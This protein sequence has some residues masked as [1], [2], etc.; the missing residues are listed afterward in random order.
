MFGV[1]GTGASMETVGKKDKSAQGGR[2]QVFERPYKGP[3]LT[4]NKKPLKDFEQKCDMTGCAS[5]EF[6][7]SLVVRTLSFHYGGK[8]KWFSQ[9][10]K[11]KKKK[12]RYQ[13]QHGRLRKKTWKQ[14]I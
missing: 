8:G 4:G 11:K 9:R 7:G 5:R 6:S 12:D 1:P 10:G 14:K 13:I 2:D 3:Q